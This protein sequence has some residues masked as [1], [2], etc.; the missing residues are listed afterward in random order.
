MDTPSTYPFNVLEHGWP[1]SLDTDNNSC[2]TSLNATFAGF[3]PWICSVKVSLY[4]AHDSLCPYQVEAETADL[5]KWIRLKLQC[6]HLRWSTT[7]QRPWGYWVKEEAHLQCHTGH[8]GAHLQHHTGQAREMSNHQPFAKWS[9]WNLST[10]C[11]VWS[12][13][14]MSALGLAVYSATVVMIPTCTCLRKCFVRKCNRQLLCVSDAFCVDLLWRQGGGLSPVIPEKN[15]SCRRSG[16][17][18]TAIPHV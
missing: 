12:R 7:V 15:C 18:M 4:S 5:S 13:L 6:L 3:Q 9:R 10:V 11:W 17:N 8:T 1:G 16:M 14:L 2:N